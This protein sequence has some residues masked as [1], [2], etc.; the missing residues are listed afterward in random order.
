MFSH[1]QKE[2]VFT[3][4][5]V[6]KNIQL[7]EFNS[8]TNSRLEFDVADDLANGYHSWDEI[9]FSVR[10]LQEKGA[11]EILHIM[12]TATRHALPHGFVLKILPKFYDLETELFDALGFSGTKRQLT[13]SSNGTTIY[14]TENGEKYKYSFKHKS[15]GYLLLNFLTQS[16]HKI[17]GFGILTKTLD[18]STN[19][20][21][22][23]VVRDAVQYIKK[24]LKLPKSEA[25]FL[26]GNGY[27]LNCDCERFESSPNNSQK[28]LQI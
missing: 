8:N 10:L 27:G 13:F 18:S 28:L 1:L 24:R 16:P 5:N 26:V 20:E 11:V 3:L 25:L 12:T 21:D 17:H 15:A 9:N 14:T 22:D 4:L 19:G 23:R 2:K 6:W 7:Q